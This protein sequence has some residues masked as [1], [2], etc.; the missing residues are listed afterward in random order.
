[1]SRVFSAAVKRKKIQIKSSSKNTLK[2]N[3]TK[4]TILSKYH[5]EENLQKHL[6]RQ[7]FVS[8]TKKIFAKQLP[9]SVD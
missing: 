5:S 7:S 1:M 3:Q 6:A 4:T 9:D 2:L 8:Q